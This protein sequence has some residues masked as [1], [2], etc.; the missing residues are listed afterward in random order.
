MPISEFIISVFC[1][2]DDELKKVLKGKNLRQRGPRPRLS[3]SEV[4]T[5]EIVGDFFGKDC[6]KD[7]V[8]QI[9]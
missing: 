6:D 9:G 7:S 2:V 3:D 5:M 4:L 1:L 8:A